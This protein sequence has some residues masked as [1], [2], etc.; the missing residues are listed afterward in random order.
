MEDFAV[1]LID[2]H[3]QHGEGHEDN[4]TVDAPVGGKKEQSGYSHGVAADA[5]TKQRGWRRAPGYGGSSFCLLSSPGDVQNKR[6]RQLGNLQQP[7]TM[8]PILQLALENT[9]SNGKGAENSHRNTQ[10]LM[11]VH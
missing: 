7:C 10:A 5:N 8:F 6:N 3:F 11:K 1:F 9:D 4:S 2:V